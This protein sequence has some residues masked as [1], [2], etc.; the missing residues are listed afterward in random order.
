M[1][2]RIGISEGAHA[3]RTGGLRGVLARSVGSFATRINWENADEWLIAE[4][5]IQAVLLSVAVRRCMLTV[6]VADGD[7]SW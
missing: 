1:S 6:A 5:K 2:C 4:T 3:Y 7:G